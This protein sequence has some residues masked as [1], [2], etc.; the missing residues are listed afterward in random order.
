MR[1]HDSAQRYAITD[2]GFLFCQDCGSLVM[3]GYRGEHDD[4]HE[5]LI[6]ARTAV[7]L[8]GDPMMRKR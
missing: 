6:P 5:G 4:M 1:S 2:A 3:E 8:N 7:T